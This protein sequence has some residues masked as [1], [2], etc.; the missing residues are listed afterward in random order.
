[1]CSTTSELFLH[2]FKQNK[3]KLIISL[4]NLWEI[5]II[6]IISIDNYSQ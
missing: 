1:M 5:I 4:N 3:Q 2:Y 6:I